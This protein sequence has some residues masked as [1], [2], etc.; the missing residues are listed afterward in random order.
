MKENNKINWLLILQG[1]AMLWV[2]IGH[3]APVNSI[4]EMPAWAAFLWNTA[5]SFHMPLFIMVS[6]FLFY[7][8]RIVPGKWNFLNMYKEKLI[9][10]GIPFVFF[11]IIGMLMK[12]VF[13]G[14]VERPSSFS[15]QDFLF[16]IISPN[17]G[18]C[19]EFWFIGAIMFLFAL[20][21]LWKYILRSWALTVCTFCI[22][23]LLY[24]FHP[25]TEVLSISFA[26]SLSSFFCLGLILGKLYQ[27]WFFL[28]ML[29]MR[30]KFIVFTR[31]RN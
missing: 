17:N 4:E 26:T 15:I 3:A 18:P 5:Y 29:S 8:T 7:I 28:Q 14:L 16:A 24:F 22:T 27:E 30:Y 31:W 9:R 2:V 10:L 20:F 13:S 23:I 1:W 25:E 11:T 6:G 21:P 19:R 12:S